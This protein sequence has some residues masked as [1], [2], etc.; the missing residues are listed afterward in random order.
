MPSYFNG[1][2]NAPSPSL[3]E[4]GVKYF[5]GGV[6]KECN[7]LREE[8]HNAV[9]NTCMLGAFVLV[10]AAVLYYKYRSKPTPEE[11]VEIRRKQQ[12]YI[13]SKLRMVNAANHAAS[14]GNFITGLPKWEV[15]EVELIKNRKIFL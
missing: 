1:P 15:P 14:R 7:R 8:Y 3:I 4:P 2:L 10:L 13:L 12:E 5:F 9:F 11:Q 6:L